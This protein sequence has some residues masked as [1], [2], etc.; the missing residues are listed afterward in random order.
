MQRFFAAHRI[1]LAATGLAASLVLAGCGHSDKAG[2]PVSADNVEMPAEEAL[3]GVTAA[4]TPDPSANATDAATDSPVGDSAVPANS[5]ATPAAK[6]APTAKLGATP[7][8]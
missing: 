2:D 8:Q 4:P 1:V 3:S 7:A 6:P 5:A